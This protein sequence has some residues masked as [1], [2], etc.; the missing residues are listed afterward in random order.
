MPPASKSKFETVRIAG[1]IVPDLTCGLWAA[2]LLGPWAVVFLQLRFLWSVHDQYSYAWSVPALAILLFSLRWRDRPPGERPHHSWWFLV[3]LLAIFPL[4]IAEEATPDWSVANWSLSLTVLALYLSLLQ[5]AGGRKWLRWFA[6]PGI[7]ALTSVPWP[8]R[9]EQSLTNGLMRWVARS[10]AEIAG[11]FSIPA[12]Q[13]GNLL[14][15]PAGCLSIEEACSGVSSLQATLMVTLFLGDLYRLPAGRRLILLGSGIILALAGNLFR[16]VLL[17]MVASRYGIRAAAA[18]HDPAGFSVLLFALMGSLLLALRLRR[19]R[20]VAVAAAS[21][22]RVAASI[23]T[24]VLVWLAAVEAGVEIWYRSHEAPH[25][26]WDWSV[27]WPREA[28]EYRESPIADRIQRTLLCND[29][30]AANWRGDDGS[31]WSL[32][33]LRWDPGKT[34]AQSARQH[35]PETC[36]TG[37]G[38]VLKEDLGTRSLQAGR[39]RFPFHAFA[40]ERGNSRFFVFFCLSEQ[41]NADL[42]TPGLLQDYSGWSRLQRA[43]A[44]QRNVGQQSLEFIVEGYA[45][46]ED[47]QAS[48]SRIL[49]TLTEPETGYHAGGKQRGG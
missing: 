34:A 40:F 13:E 46:A 37:S 25:R 31:S 44:G 4:R 49:P 47:A 39:L 5:R 43:F 14:V 30:R 12:V 16:N 23:A 11:W 29:G 35:R 42:G 32:Y 36:L 1:G 28:R 8:Q 20:P 45:R 21:P 27:R 2:A 19:E 17:C 15:L 9:F 26:G 10:A 48:L 22:P 41:G 6:F 7:F 24:G 38:A 33:W 3:P 18:W